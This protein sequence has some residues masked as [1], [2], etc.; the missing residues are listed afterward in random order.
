MIMRYFFKDSNNAAGFVSVMRQN[1][2]LDS[3][4]ITTTPQE[5]LGGYFVVIA[6]DTES[7]EAE[8]EI[9]KSFDEWRTT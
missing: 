3:A 8:R 6:I 9:R 2:K 7:G 5:S 1:S 4:L